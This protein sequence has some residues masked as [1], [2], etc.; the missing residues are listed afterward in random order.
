VPREI[1]S[2]GA[3]QI[4]PTATQNYKDVTLKQHFFRNDIAA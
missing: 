3:N 1:C 2:P 4:L